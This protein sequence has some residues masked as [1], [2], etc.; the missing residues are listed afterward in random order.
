MRLQRVLQE[1]SLS[2]P[3]DYH[4][5]TGAMAT[6][7][8]ASIPRSRIMHILIPFL[9]VLFGI[10][11]GPHLHPTA[12][13]KQVRSEFDAFFG[14]RLRPNMAPKILD[15]SSVEENFVVKNLK[16]ILP[17]MRNGDVE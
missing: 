16:R 11:L 7:P 3:L 14:R 6:A 17:Q 12:P 10:F 15:I 5:N 2:R 9:I 13:M 8:V 4:I 1:L